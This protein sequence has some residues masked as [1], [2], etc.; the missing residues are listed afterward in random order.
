[1][2][3]ILFAYHL[4]GTLPPEVSPAA[5][6][7]TQ[8]RIAP[9][10]AVY[11][12]ATGA[13]AQAAARTAAAA[14]RGLAGRLRRHHGRLGDLRQP[15]HR[16]PHLRRRRRAR[17]STRPHWARASRKGKDTLYKHAI[18]GFHGDGGRDA[19]Q[20][21][22]PGADRRPGQGHRRLDARQHQVSRDVADAISA[23]RRLRAALSFPASLHAANGRCVH[24]A[25]HEHAH[26]PRCRPH[27]RP[28]LLLDGPAGA[29]EA[30]RRRSA[31]P[32][33]ARAIVAIVCHPLPTEGGTMHN[34]VV[35]MAARALREVRRRHGALQ[36]PR[37]RQLAGRPSTKATAKPTTCSRS[38]R[39]VAR[40]T[41][42]RARC[43][44]PA[45]ASAP[46]SSLRAAR[47]TAARRCCSRSRRRWAAA[48]TSTTIALPNCPWLVIQG[49]ADE[50]VDAQA[51]RAW[52]EAMRRPPE[53]VLMP[54]TSH[55][56]HRKL[57]RPARR[58]QER[59]AP[60]PAAPRHDVAARRR[61][62]RPTRA[63]VARGDWQDDPAQHGALRELD[64]IH[65]A[66]AQRARARRPGSR[67][68][69]QRRAEPPRGLYLWGGV[70]RGKTFLIDLFFA[71]L[72]IAE[73]RRTHFHRFMRDVHARLRA[74]AGAARSAGGD[75]ARMARRSCACWC[76]T[77]SS[78][79]TSATRCC[80]GDCSSACS[81]KAWCW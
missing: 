6:Q 60:L 71:G 43:G 67:A 2:A 65:A 61:R 29:L 24:H 56:F 70:G 14:G 23:Q 10:G 51:V 38:R 18:E 73:K 21:R 69:R 55:F 79:A 64:R 1:M 44:W 30:R 25:P 45:S 15:V 28:T 12:G 9:A 4:Q 20:G 68:V 52:I 66:L 32:R 5:A 46:T 26:A 39:W 3:L 48:G 11:A 16:L 42:G 58:D 40:A 31:R 47:R 54:D 72:P 35:T 50:I 13:A 76:S 62:R 22:Q 63:G 77:N 81:P 37:H 17:R 8:D 34:K 74:H 59:R 19:A 57:H 78:S 7:R 75:R 27:R 36:L 33:R 41:P 53:L 49:E 80:W